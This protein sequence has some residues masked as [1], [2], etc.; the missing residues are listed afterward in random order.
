MIS[1]TFVSLGE[2]AIILGRNRNTIARWIRTGKIKGERIG[3]L[4]LIRQEEL[5][6]LKAAQVD[7]TNRAA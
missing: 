3:N 1:G 6:R 5:E 7:Q 2:A 4:V